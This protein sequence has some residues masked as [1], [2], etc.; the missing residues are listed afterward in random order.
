MIMVIQNLRELEQESISKG[1]PI[2][3]EEKGKW[4][5]EKVKQ[6]QPKRILE[7]G[8]A[9][10]Y[11]GCILGSEGGE[12]TTIEIDG[13]I[14]EEAMINFGKHNV[15]AKVLIGDGVKITKELAINGDKFDLIFIDFALNQYIE[16][17]EDCIKL[18]KPNA[19]IIVDNI[20]LEVKQR[21]CQDFKEAILNHPNLKSEI[22][23]I[24]DG[25]CY[26]VRQ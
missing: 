21:N 4:L 20:N 2:I 11:S 13:K 25:L 22:I 5:L 12:L 18:T 15:N 24:K 17:L 3:G 23:N 14:A 1:I 10:G 19:V 8:T 16:V 7:L 26:C 6:H 9:N